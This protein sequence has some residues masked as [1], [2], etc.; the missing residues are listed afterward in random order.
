MS[1]RSLPILPLAVLLSL[2]ALTF[3]LNQFVQV[4]GARADS[5]L[6]HDPDIVV[7]NFTAKA[8]GPTGDVQYTVKAAKM[9]HFP[10]DD[11]SLMETVVFT[12]IHQDLPPIVAESPRGRLVEGADE[13]IMEGGVV[14]TSEKSAKYPPLKLST[15]ILNMFPDQDLVKANS[16]V[17]IESPTDQLTAN[18][19]EL[20]SL[21]R[22]LRLEQGRAIYQQPQRI[23]R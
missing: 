14:V 11:S 22:T 13:V 3:W 10:D 7:E 17:R 18:K 19:M 15:P 2:V 1:T 16:G 20:N 12:S 6:R 21:T 9:S 8:L 4:P 23:P 5:N